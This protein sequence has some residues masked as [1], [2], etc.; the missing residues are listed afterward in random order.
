MARESVA[1]ISAGASAGTAMCAVITESTPASIAALNG[2]SSTR[3]RRSR[4]AGIVG[5]VHVAVHRRVAVP[6]KMLD[7]GQDEIFLVRVRSFDECLN[8]FRHRLRIFA[9]RSDVDDRDYR[10]CC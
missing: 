1:G 3:S 2:T 5:Q 6:G 4:S 8:L 7:R 9:E 10:G